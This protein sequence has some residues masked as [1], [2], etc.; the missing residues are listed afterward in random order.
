MRARPVR[1]QDNTDATGMVP[2]PGFGLPDQGR[3][4]E[5]FARRSRAAQ[6]IR[7]RHAWV[8]NVPVAAQYSHR[9]FRFTLMSGPPIVRVAEPGLR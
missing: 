3:E 5:P 2:H 8:L 1:H 6:P 9:A 4:R 7:R